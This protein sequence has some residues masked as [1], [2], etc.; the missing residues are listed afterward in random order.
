MS[1]Q[2]FTEELLK[3][4]DK[5]F[6][7]EANVLLNEARQ[8]SNKIGYTAGRMDGL[9]SASTEV[10]RVYNLFV[11]EKKVEEEDEKPLY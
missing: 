5:I 11:K 9:S 10:K 6:E 7:N 4:L 1:I 3:A 2:S 8:Q